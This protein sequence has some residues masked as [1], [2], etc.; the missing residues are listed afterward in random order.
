M[1]SSHKDFLDL[2]GWDDF[3]AQHAPDPT[4]NKSVPARVISEERKLY[5]VQVGLKQS[6]W[7]AISGK[8]QHEAQSRIHYPAVGDW[9]DVEFSSPTERGLIQKIYPRK[10]LLQRQQA[11]TSGDLQILSA[12]VDYVFITTSVN[13][14]LNF[15]RIERYLSIAWEAGTIPII[16]LTKA[17][18]VGTRVDEL[19]AG[20]K[21]EFPSVDV[22]GLSQND[23]GAAKFLVHYLRAGKSAVFLGSSGVGKSTL[24][25]YLIGEEQIK[26]QAVR[27]DDGK[28][29]HTTTS[30]NLYVSR[31]GGLVIDTPGMRELQ[32]ADHSEGVRAQFADLENLAAGCR[33]TDCK[34]QTEPGCVIKAGLSDGTL[35]AARWESYQKLEA[36]IRHG[37]RKQDKAL[38]S[39]DR[40]SWKKLTSEGKKRGRSKKGL[41]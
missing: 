6:L 3:F 38:A 34:H 1:P 21:K 20:I 13:E 22:Q 27:E 41:F 8:M 29:R 15:R 4:L 37:L 17:D 14:D 11:G 32:L 19:I 30:R 10:T 26:T 12:N 24:V 23:F 7:A 5:R 18:I 40:K 39:E 36:E 33:F 35:S 31:F 16:L 2:F 28:G 9:V 25:N